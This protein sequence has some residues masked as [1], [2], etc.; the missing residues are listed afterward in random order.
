MEWNSFLAPIDGYTDLPFRLLCRKYGAA[1]SCVPLVNSTA[2]ARR[3]DMLG[4]VDANPAE[5]NCGIQLV[6]NSPEDTA[7]ATKALA[8]AFPFISWLNLN[9][10]CPSPRTVGTG[11]GSALLRRPKLMLAMLSAMK[12]HS[13]AQVSVKLRVKDGMAKTAAL[14]RQL[15][16]AGADFIILHGRTPAQGYSG[17]ADW[18]LIRAVRARIGIRLVGNGDI[19]SASEGRRMVAAGYCDA[20]MAGRAAMSNPLLFSDGKPDGLAGRFGLLREYI[21]LGRRHGRGPQLKDIKL[22]ALSLVSGVPD[23]GALRS[24]ISRAVAAGDILALEK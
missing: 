4:T 24:A 11:G 5:K 14:C 18:E 9:C 3:P 13:P 2:I 23:A 16:H 8:D 20:F 1:A 15:E 21:S 12:K 10:G 6:G 7:T 22:K 17:R 19:S